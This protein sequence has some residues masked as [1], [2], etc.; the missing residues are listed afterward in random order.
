MSYRDDY[1]QYRSSGDRARPGPPEPPTHSPALSYRPR[2]QSSSQYLD[3]RPPSGN[4]DRSYTPATMA[5]Y[6]PLNE[7]S[8]PYHS[9]AS[10]PETYVADPAPYQE[11]PQRKPP[12][13]ERNKCCRC[14]CCACCLPVWARWILWIIIIAII[15]VVV[16]FAIIFSQFKV[17]NFEFN[18]VTSSPSGLSQ[19]TVNGTSWNIN[20]GL[21]IGI[22]NPNI[23]SATL[24]DMN[25]TAYYPTSPTMPVGG[26][27]LAEQGVAANAITNFTFPFTIN[28]DPTEDKDQAILTDIATKCGLLGGQKQQLT[29]NY[30]I[31]LAVKVLFVT[32]HPSISNSASFDCPITNGELPELPSGVLGSLLPSSSSTS[33]S[34]DSGDSGDSSS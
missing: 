25:A 19:F 4:Y 15:I 27:F 5:S 32:V 11:K 13:T 30:K 6:A 31:T 29:I 12:L 16:V 1:M 2:P 26:G 23:E 9:S 24:S 33:S 21:K 34:D 18:G 20:G 7:P 28:Y 10:P 14:L 3:E 22:N 8:P 17:P